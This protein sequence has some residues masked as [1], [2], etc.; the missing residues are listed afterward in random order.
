MIKDLNLSREGV[1]VLTLRFKEWNLLIDNC[2]VGVQKTRHKEYSKFYSVEEDLCF[3]KDV[4]S[5]FGAIGIDH[6]L[7][8]GRLFIDSS[9]KSLKAVLLHNG[10]AWPLIPV[11]HST[12]IKEDYINVK[13]LLNKIGHKN[14]K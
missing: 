11:G 13:I 10:N 6:I 4:E 2:K 7:S 9:V 3:C 8:E 12:H 1:Q 5:L 14:F